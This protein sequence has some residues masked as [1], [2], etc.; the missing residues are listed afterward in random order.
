MTIGLAAA[1]TVAVAAGAI[2]GS[3]KNIKTEAAS[4]A[5]HCLPTSD[6]SFY[7]AAYWNDNGWTSAN[8]KIWGYFWDANGHNCWTSSCVNTDDWKAHHDSSGNTTYYLVTP[9]NNSYTWTGAQL[10]RFDSG[11]STTRGTEWNRTANISLGNSFNYVGPTATN[12]STYNVGILNINFFEGGGTYYLDLSNGNYDWLSDS[13]KIYAHLWA[14]NNLSSSTDVEM[15]QVL[16][17]SNIYLYQ[18][19]VPS[20]SDFHKLIFHRGTTSS[21]YSNQTGT[22]NVNTSKNVYKLTSYEGA[23]SWDWNLSN[24]DRANYYGTYFLSQITCGGTEG[25]HAGTITSEASHWTNVSNEY[26]RISTTIQGLIWD[27][28]ASESGTDLQKAMYRYDYI[29]FKKAYSS[30]NDFMHR[31]ASEHKA[32]ANSMQLIAINDNTNSTMLIV[33]FSAIALVSAAGFFFLKKKRA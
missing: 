22:L 1:A 24:A 27:S 8:A 2:A 15:T 10:V 29:V 13:H 7:Y 25:E 18:L 19:V 23:G 21:G 33:A 14:G 31:T 32:F 9:S 6:G 17:F 12:G 4:T 11:S 26:N 3:S 20:T 30:Y 5:S 16:G 28:T